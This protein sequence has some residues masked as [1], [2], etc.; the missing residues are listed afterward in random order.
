MGQLSLV[1][2]TPEPVS[3]KE[4]GCDTEFFVRMAGKAEILRYDEE[5][6]GADP[7]VEFKKII[8]GLIPECIAAR[9]KDRLLLNPDGSVYVSGQLEKKLYELNVMSRI[10]IKSVRLTSESEEAYREKFGDLTPKN[11]FPQV[12][13][14][15][16]EGKAHG[17]LIHFSQNS[18]SHGMMM[19]SGSFSSDTLDWLADGSV[20][21][22]YTYNGGGKSIRSEYRVNPETAEKMRVFV[23]EKHLAELSEKKIETPAVFDCFTSTSLSM[24]FDDRKVGG[25]P[26]ETCTLQCGPAGMTFADIEKEI[27]GIIKECRETGECVFNDTKET[28]GGPVG[29]MGIFGMGIG[30][31]AVSK[32]EKKPEEI[33]A[34]PGCWVC[35]KCGYNGNEGKFCSECGARRESI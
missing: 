19:G 34:L 9:P 22:T 14:D 24:T 35:S 20:I 31:T 8:I 15:G 16:V 23:K 1:F 29:M 2:G 17:T 6:Y 11:P 4:D 7:S 12:K 5:K 18:T 21:L 33:K 27:N 10:E 30:M 28:G 25:S 26:Y 32:P 3:F 13:T